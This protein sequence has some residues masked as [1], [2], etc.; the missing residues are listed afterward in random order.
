MSDK[1][2]LMKYR[3]VTI[4]VGFEINLNDKDRVY[5]LKDGKPITVP[6]ISDVHVYDINPNISFEDCIAEFIDGK[7]NMAPMSK[8]QGM[9]RGVMNV[10]GALTSVGKSQIQK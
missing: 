10:V 1:V 5:V 3:S 7:G 2:E 9:R 4:A 8:M 6:A